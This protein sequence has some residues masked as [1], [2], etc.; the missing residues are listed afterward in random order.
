MPYIQEGGSGQHLLFFFN[1]VTHLHYEKGVAIAKCNIT[2][3]NHR[4]HLGSLYYL[5]LNVCL[6]FGVRRCFHR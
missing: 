5:L 3:V 6:D 2:K 4:Y 1:I